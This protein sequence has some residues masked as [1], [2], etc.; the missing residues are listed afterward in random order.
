MVIS[1]K[2]ADIKIIN[3]NKIQNSGKL[4][5]S[6]SVKVN[7]KKYVTLKYPINFSDLFSL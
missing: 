4:K 5:I 1:T 6:Q 7:K 2:S 3:K